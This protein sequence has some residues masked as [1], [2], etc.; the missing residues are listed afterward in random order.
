M[1]DNF[2]NSKIILFS[3]D[4]PFNYWSAYRKKL[5]NVYSEVSDERNIYFYGLFFEGLNYNTHFLN[6]Q[7]HPNKQGYQIISENIASYLLKN[8]IIKN[9]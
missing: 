8:N 5:K 7:I 3:I 2:P 1:V 4:L 9:D 6:D